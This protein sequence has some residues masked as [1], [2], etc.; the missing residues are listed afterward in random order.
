VSSA[1]AVS[2]EYSDVV[3][4][5]EAAPG[6]SY[7][8]VARRVGG[9]RTS[10]LA[11][12]K[13]AVAAG[14]VHEG[15][16]SV[17][18]RGGALRSTVGLFPHPPVD[19]DA[20]ALPLTYV[21]GETAR[22]MRALAGVSR[23]AV[24]RQLGVSSTLIYRWEDGR[25]PL[26]TWAVQTLPAALEDAQTP[27]RPAR[28]RDARRLR[29]LV[30]QVHRSPGLTRWQLAGPRKRD[31][32]LLEQARRAGQL[33]EAPTWTGR[34]RF[35]AVGLYPGARPRL[36]APRPVRVDELHRA[37]LA[38]GWTNQSC[39]I[40]I[41]VAGTTLAR[42]QREL[43]VVP[44]WANDGAARALAEART[45]A[46]DD[47]GAVLAAVRAE[48]GL[49]LK[50]LTARLGFTR[51]PRPGAAVDE[52][53]AVG[54]LHRRHAGRRGQ[55][56]GLFPGPAPTPTLTP[57]H[58]RELRGRTGLEQRAL[59]ELVGTHVQAVRD[60]EGGR[61]PMSLE[62]QHQLRATLEQL[63]D[64]DELLQQAVLA[65]LQRSPRTRHGLHQLQLASRGRTEDAIDALLAAGHVQEGP[66]GARQRRRG[67][68]P[69][70]D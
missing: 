24:A 31:R 20:Q 38:A 4:V 3:D 54:A 10:T 2:V 8:E 69:R 52:L 70:T 48:P 19:D 51:S 12:L 55:R 53:E 58:L 23:E 18:A 16:S 17:R 41:G 60:W 13:A 36:Q 59:A 1:A 50:T 11:R 30:A 21:S 7:A 42:W 56:D 22:A 49:S 32:Q 61:R 45:H 35:P 25:Q 67:L 14:A 27:E 44:A 64:V 34:S 43:E 63:P 46:R 6:L 29:E 57:Q 39:A 28:R 15:A 47:Q 68:L 33:H 40:R 37:R 26:P 62:W 9:R 5:V 66:I 65:E